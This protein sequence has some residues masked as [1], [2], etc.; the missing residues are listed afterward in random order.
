MII[1][2]SLFL[3]HY[4]KDTANGYTLLHPLRKLQ[5]YKQFRESLGMSE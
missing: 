5:L 4:G 2:A 3:D 1:E